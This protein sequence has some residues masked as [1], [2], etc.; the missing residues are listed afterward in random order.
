MAQLKQGT[1][2]DK[3]ALTVTMGVVG[4]LFPVLGLTTLLCFLLALLL[5]LNQ[6]IIHVINQLLW[7]VHLAMI[8][9]YIKIG[10]TL[11]GA[12]VMP[13]DAEEVSRL[14]WH[15][16]REF[17]ARFGLMGLHATSAWLLSVPVIIAAI[18]F[19]LRPVVRRLAQSRRIRSVF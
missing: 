9:V 7:P 4:G 8:V 11:Y 15:S 5:R 19:P 12:A 3:I 10:A 6:P 1:S 17:W 16:Q 14:F 2:P 18:Y 13:F